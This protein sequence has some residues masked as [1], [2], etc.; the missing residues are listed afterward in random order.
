M[1]EG[2]GPMNC[3]LVEE[4]YTAYREGELEPQEAREFAAHLRECPRCAA[5]VEALDAVVTAMRDL[6]PVVPPPG[7]R[8]RV[9]D[10]VAAARGGEVV[11]ADFARRA[12]PTT[13]VGDPRAR[14]GGR[15]CRL[16]R[17]GQTG[18][19]SLQEG[20]VEVRRVHD[21]PRADGA[22]SGRRAPAGP[23]AAPPA[24]APAPVEPGVERRAESK[25]GPT[26]LPPAPTE[27]RTLPSQGAISPRR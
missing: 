12:E 20:G 26:F 2:T 24:A 8:E 25:G 9:L 17:G 1:D 6:R 3:G 4:L 15:V 7:L 27:G 16:H 14:G 5:E 18:N 21:R 22:G 19:G 13:H 23:L 10:A 11:E